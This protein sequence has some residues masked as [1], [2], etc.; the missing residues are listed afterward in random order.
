M[1]KFSLTWRFRHTR[2]R[3]QNSKDQIPAVVRAHARVFLVNLCR[4]FIVHLLFKFRFQWGLTRRPS[5][6]MTVKVT[7]LFERHIA[8][9]TVEFWSSVRS[10]KVLPSQ[11]I[12]RQPV[13][14]QVF[15]E[16]EKNQ[17]VEPYFSR[18]IPGQ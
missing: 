12:E 8:A 13:N 14:S 17:K 16:R 1:F 9:W 11:V 2:L 4:L 10:V 6:Q 7:L 18:E 3:K 5:S 15:G